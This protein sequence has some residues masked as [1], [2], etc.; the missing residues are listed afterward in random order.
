LGDKPKSLP[1]RKLTP[2]FKERRYLRGRR[3]YSQRRPVDIRLF[4]AEALSAG[5]QFNERVGIRVDRSLAR[6]TV[7]SI[8]HAGL[9]ERILGAAYPAMGVC[10]GDGAQQR[11]RLGGDVRGDGRYSMESCS[12]AEIDSSRAS[13][14]RWMPDIETSA[15]A[16]LR[17]AHSA[18]A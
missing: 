9:R 16:A 18:G 1:I 8:A 11:G 17:A 15:A 4:N 3:G 6:V 10:R 5:A 7:T 14:C 2:R 13:A 12:G